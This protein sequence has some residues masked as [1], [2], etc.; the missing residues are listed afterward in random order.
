MKEG[1]RVLC[2][3]YKKLDGQTRDL[4]RDEIEK[5]LIYGGL[6][7]LSCPLKNDTAKYIKILRKANLRNIMITG[8]SMYTAANTG[9]KLQFG[10]SNHVFLVENKAKTGFEWINIKDEKVEDLKADRLDTLIKDR[11][12]C[13][14]GTT[15]KTLFQAKNKELFEKVILVSE[16]FARVSPDQKET[17]VKILKEHG[18]NVLMCG[19]GTNDVGALKESDVGIALV[20][21]KDEPTKE[22]KKLEKERKAKI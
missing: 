2:L 20:G 10:S 17:I 7:I 14:E 4:E 19:D 5:D 18:N 9:A 8:D 6:L 16:I 15:M 21:L 13:L 12:L 1:Y 11:C 3:A 22:D